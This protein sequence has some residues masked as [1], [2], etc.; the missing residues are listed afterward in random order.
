M[1]VSLPTL[2]SSQSDFLRQLL[3][4]QTRVTAVERFSALHDA[5]PDGGRPREMLQ[6]PAQARFY[7]E[8]LPATPPSPGQHYAFEVDLNACSGCKACVVACH[9][10]NGLDEDESWRRVGTLTIGD[11]APRL[12]H[13]TT[14]CHHCADPGCL[15]GCPVKAYHKDPVTGIVRHLDDQC[16]GCKYCTMMCPYEVPTYNERLGIVR[17]CDMCQQRLSVGEA[18]ACV[19][20]CPNAAISIRLVADAPVKRNASDRLSPGAPLSSITSPTTRYCGVSPQQLSQAKPQDAE[21]DQP[22]ES[23]WPLALMLVATQAAVGLLVVERFCHYGAPLLGC[24]T[25]SAKITLVT[26]CT[27]FIAA[28]LGLAAAGLH[29]GQPLRAWRVFLGLKTSWLSREALLFGQTMGLL[30]GSIVLSAKQTV[31]VGLSSLSLG[32]W[33]PLPQT[34]SP[35]LPDVLA[36]E[37]L[38]EGLLLMTTLSGMVALISSGMIYI[39][40]QRNLWRPSRTFG[41]FLATG[42]CL[43]CV[44][45]GG[46][47]SWL[48]GPPAVMAAV[49]AV[50]AGG[51]AIKLFWE[52]R[53]LLGRGGLLDCD[54][55]R[56]SRKLARGPLNTLRMLRLISGCVACLLAAL[57]VVGAASTAVTLTLATAVAAVLSMLIGE[58]SERLLYFS[59]VVYDRMPGTLP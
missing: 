3:D 7:K 2:E 19:Q 38:A 56:R 50:A 18:P 35:L 20:A 47:L 17:K 6:G 23:H 42:L 39:V 11:T 21:L 37:A 1:S 28:A 40:T 14:A 34:L 26:L 15:K 32:H 49:F 10:L 30:F 59:S 57:A 13:I 31:Q 27:A 5:T 58:V 9:T 48:A 55:D 44:F 45:F 41:R 33:L 25:P 29:L 36:S 54:H 46:L 24:A 53:W 16:I 51:L 12:Q 8:L 43:G 52:G 4:E 22:A